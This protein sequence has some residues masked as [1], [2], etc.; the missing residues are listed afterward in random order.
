LNLDMSTYLETPR[1]ILRQFTADDLDS[2][3][4][5]DADP[6]VMHF[7]TAGVPTSRDELASDY[8]PAYL[9]YYERGNRWGFWVAEEKDTG[10]FLG[11]FHLRPHAGDPED[12]PEL[13]YRLIAAAWGQGYATEGSVALID[14]AFTQLGAQ[15]VYAHTMA[16]HTAS[17]RVMEKAG[18]Q[19]VRTFKAD[20][21][22]R[23]EGDEQGD[24]EYA[25]TLKEWVAMRPRPNVGLS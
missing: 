9:A 11:W 21:P 3:V 19:L 1:L 10:R 23:I 16:M 4:S 13:G 2:L 7:I 15:R 6:A 14:K 12:E 5:L 24:V 18:L 20:W 22:I 25:L 8:I 17:R